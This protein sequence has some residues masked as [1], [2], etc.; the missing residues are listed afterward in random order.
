MKE[1]ETLSVKSCKTLKSKNTDYPTL[2]VTS[3]TFEK[4]L[5]QSYID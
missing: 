2:F 5:F 1:V 4:N 3:V